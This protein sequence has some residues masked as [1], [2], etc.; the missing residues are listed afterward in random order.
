MSV[1]ALGVWSFEGTSIGFPDLKKYSVKGHRNGSWY[2]LR[3]VEKAL[4]RAS[5]WFT[6]VR[7]YIV[8]SK[9]SR[10]LRAIFQKLSG[11]KAKAASAGLE[12]A[13]ELKALYGK[14]GSWATSVM[15][16]LEET[17]FII[18]LG[19]IKLNEGSYLG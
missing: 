11:F 10:M 4:F 6:R 16:W 12:R 2:K 18:Y 15:K 13:G 17:G 8:S 19:V 3:R 7:S 14:A 1:S 9:V 5:M